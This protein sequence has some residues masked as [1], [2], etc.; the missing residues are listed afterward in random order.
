MT[1]SSLVKI[2]IK[3]HTLTNRRFVGY[4]V[5]GLWTSSK[6][7]IDVGSSGSRSEQKMDH[8]LGVIF[9]SKPLNIY[10]KF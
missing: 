1:L 3:A 9:N 6:S 10:K 5:L 2:G 4:S 8:N 7:K